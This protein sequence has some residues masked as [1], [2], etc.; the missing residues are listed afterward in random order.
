MHK[1]IFIALRRQEILLRA[2]GTC[3]I[4]CAQGAQ[5][6]AP[7]V[8]DDASV[9]DARSCQFEAWVNGA[10]GARDY[11]AAPACNFF[12][13][14]I[15]LSLGIGGINPADEPSSQ[16]FE[17]RAIRRQRGR[18]VG[19]RE[20][21]EYGHDNG[22]T[23]EGA[24]STAYYAKALFSYFPD[25][26]LEIDLNLGASNDFGAGTIVAAGAALHYEF[27]PKTT[28]FAELFRNEKGP[29]KYQLGLRYAI[30]RSGSRLRRYGGVWSVG[31][32]GGIGH[33][34]GPT[35][36][37]ASSTA[38]YAK[39][40]FSYFPDEALEIDLNLGASNDFGAG[41]IVA[42]GAALHYE[43]LPKTTA[44]AEILP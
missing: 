28:A 9:I 34:N 11:W 2:C 38:Y 25:E 35:A 42:A 5:A 12:L 7:L 13:G 20:S 10:R 37:G 43:F 23:A 8:T 21:A 40:L 17:T 27:L 41:T 24:S 1:K 18:V 39:A 36:E 16:Q 32:V 14:N 22:P 4:A 30:V 6:G 44:F 26:A 29:G 15:E 33:D 19:R 31:A 3:L